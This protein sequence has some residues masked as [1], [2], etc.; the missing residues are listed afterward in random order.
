MADEDGMRIAVAGVVVGLVATNG[1]T[2]HVIAER[3]RARTAVIGGDG[4]Q[5]RCAADILDTSIRFD[6]DARRSSAL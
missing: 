6:E 2:V 4:G 1:L 3:H 5:L